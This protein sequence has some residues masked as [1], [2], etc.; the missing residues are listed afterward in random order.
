[1]PN[2]AS[3]VPVFVPFEDRLG[4][5]EWHGELE[6]LFCGVPADA[7]GRVEVAFGALVHERNGDVHCVGWGEQGWSA[8]LVMSVSREK[9]WQMVSLDI[10][11]GVVV[12]RG[13]V[14]LGSGAFTFLVETC[15]VISSWV[16]SHASVFPFCER[17]NST[18]W[19]SEILSPGTTSW[20]LSC[21]WGWGR[22]VRFASG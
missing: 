6:R 9:V 11:S 18:F 15:V 14:V 21:V 20:R 16:L 7:G 17:E 12:G 13:V 5:L 22:L 19:S 10:L 4:Y 2:N 3:D 8:M 1:M